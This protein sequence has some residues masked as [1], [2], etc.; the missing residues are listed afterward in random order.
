MTIFGHKGQTLIETALILFLLLI[1]VFGITEFARAWYTKNSLKNAVRQGAR[2]A[3]V[4]S[5][6]TNFTSSIFSCTNFS[7]TTP[8]TDQLMYAVCCQPG[9]PK[10]PEN[11]T[12]ITVTCYDSS[13]TLLSSCAGSSGI[14]SG[15]T[16]KVS[17]STTF[18]FMIGG[19]PWPWSKTVTIT[20]DASMRYE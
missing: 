18:F 8:S 16:V 2:V 17:G 13:G 14:V 4:L 6:N 19:A 12:T 15:G 5:P 20:T 10:R 1:V 11:A 7:C 9:I 3:A